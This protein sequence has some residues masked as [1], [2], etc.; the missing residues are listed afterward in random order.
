VSRTVSIVVRL[1]A[2]FQS[3]PN[4]TGGFVWKPTLLQGITVPYRP[5]IVV[6]D[7]GTPQL[8]DALNGDG[9]LKSQLLK[10]GSGLQTRASHP[11]RTLQSVHVQP[12]TLS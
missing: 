12:R 5:H 3:Q 9:V 4:T 1:R 11:G 8:S 10:I 6:H 2:Q 7:G